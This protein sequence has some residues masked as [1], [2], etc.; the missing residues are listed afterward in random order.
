[1]YRIRADLIKIHKLKKKTSLGNEGCK[2]ISDQLGCTICDLL[3][4]RHTVQGIYL[5]TLSPLIVTGI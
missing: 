3:L 2:N 1:M 5:L 4:N